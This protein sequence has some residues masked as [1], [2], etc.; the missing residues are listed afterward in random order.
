MLLWP[1][2]RGL[3]LS[4]AG[5]VVSLAVISAVWWRLERGAVEQRETVLWNAYGVGGAAL[6]TVPLGFVGSG[7]F[8]V[9]LQ[10]LLLL[11]TCAVAVIG[12]I[13]PDAVDIR[14]LIVTSVV[15]AVT[16]MVILALFSGTAAV[17][18]LAPVRRRRWAAWP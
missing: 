10:V 17:I 16:V 12:V 7:W 8:P 1:Q 18:Q 2:Q 5:L 9:V 15:Y 13:S 14:L 11:G 4:I 6:L 3:V